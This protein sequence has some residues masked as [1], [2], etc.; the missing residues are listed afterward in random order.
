MRCDVKGC[1]GRERDVRVIA[2]GSL[3][4]GIGDPNYGA[5]PGRDGGGARSTTEIQEV[6]IARTGTLRLYFTK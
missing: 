3:Y 1:A 5:D 2:S 4:R 6:E